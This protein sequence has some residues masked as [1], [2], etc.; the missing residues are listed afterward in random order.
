MKTA[1]IMVKQGYWL[2]RYRSYLPLVILAFALA[3]MWT[4]R[5][6]YKS[7]SVLF[8]ILCLCI[9]LCGETIRIIT[10]GFAPNRTSGRNR[11]K[12]VAKELNQTGIY[13]LFRHPLYVGNF[14]MWLGIAIYS[15]IWWL[16]IIF[17]LVYWLYYERIIMAEEDFLKSKF[18]EDYEQYSSR[19]NAILPR[20]KAYVQNKYT[21][22][23]K[24]ALR[25]DYSSFYGL[26]VVFLAVRLYQNWLGRGKISLETHWIAIGS[27]FTVLYLILLA[28]WKWTK[29]LKI[30]KETEKKFSGE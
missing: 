13:S 2:F 10:V 16:V 29:L 12:Q 30:E 4:H 26:I 9:S 20:F 14:F 11:T 27:T 24:K 5:T 15:K 1:D 6:M 25:Q 23:F 8:D 18:G 28:L 17:I 19:V 3:C 22:R 21:F 7:D